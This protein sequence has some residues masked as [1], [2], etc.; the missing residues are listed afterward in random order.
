MVVNN[1]VDSNMAVSN[2]VVSNMVDNNTVV[3]NMVVSNTVDK[4]TISNTMKKDA[5][6]KSSLLKLARCFGSAMLNSK[7][8]AAVPNIGGHT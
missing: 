2:T 4:A 5:S 1:M 6:V 3:S 7:D 8:A